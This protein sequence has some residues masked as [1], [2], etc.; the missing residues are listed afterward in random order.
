[1]IISRLKEHRVKDMVMITVLIS[2]LDEIQGERRVRKS[3]H[4][5][6]KRAKYYT[7]YGKNNNAPKRKDV[8]SH[9]KVK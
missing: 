8:V 6:G 1:M 5:G 9:T 2:A 4:H 7:N 3:D